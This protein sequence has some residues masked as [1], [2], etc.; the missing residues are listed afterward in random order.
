MVSTSSSRHCQCLTCVCVCVCTGD[1][2][3]PCT[4]DFARWMTRSA[5]FDHQTY[6]DRYP[7]TRDNTEEEDSHGN[8]NEE[9]TDQV[10][11]PFCAPPSRRTDPSL[12]DPRCESWSRDLSRDV[13]RCPARKSTR[14]KHKEHDVRMIIASAYAHIRAHVQISASG[15]GAEACQR[16]CRPGAPWI[17]VNTPYANGAA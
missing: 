11:L 7:Y 3:S 17:I 6:T 5:R 12:R 9:F 1:G 4:S 2:T 13:L 10:V 16:T 15:A 14:R 8:A